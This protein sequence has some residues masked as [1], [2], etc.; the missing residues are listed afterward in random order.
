[1]ITTARAF[2]LTAPEPLERE[3][4]E[5]CVRLLDQIIML[6]AKWFPY[7]AG[8]AELSPQQAAQFA[9][10]GLK[11]G[12]PDL[13]FLHGSVYCIELKRS[14]GRLSK[15]RIVRS[16][17]GD[18]RVVAGQEENF[19]QLI[20]TGAVKDIAICHNVDEVLGCL[21]AW[22]IPHRRAA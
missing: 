3:L 2:R 5:R 16:K 21:A 7:P 15:T 1:M 6:P 18:L 8:A 4:H 13:W 10:F 12:M 22:N 14:G 20:A 17:R 19:P 9:R 11:A